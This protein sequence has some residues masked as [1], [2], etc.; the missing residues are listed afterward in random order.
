MITA[1]RIKEIRLAQGLTVENVA[2]ELGIAKSNYS[3][4]ENGKVEISVARLQALS[5]IF[6]LPISAFMPSN[7]N[8]TF[9]ISNG[10]HAI[11]ATEYNNYSDDNLV[12]SLM[13]TITMLEDIVTKVKK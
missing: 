4:M 1:Q 8:T 5:H 9:N 12:Q 10:S 7:Q 3:N 2:Q 6:K 11:N 13:K